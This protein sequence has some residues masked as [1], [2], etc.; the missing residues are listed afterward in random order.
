MINSGTAEPL[1]KWG[2]L[3]TSAGG[4]SLYGGLGAS[5]TISKAYLV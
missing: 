1:L 3:Q 4:V 5:D 2:A